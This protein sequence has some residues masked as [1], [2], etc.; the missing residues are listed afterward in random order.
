MLGIAGIAFFCTD[1]ASHLFCNEARIGVQAEEDSFAL[2]KL[3]KQE[4]F[5]QTAGISM[6]T[7][8][9]SF[10][11]LANTLLQVRL[12]ER[13]KAGPVKASTTVNTGVLKQRLKYIQIF[14]PFSFKR[15]IGDL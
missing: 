12:M 5:Q 3:R 8:K 2:C 1:R 14:K 7:L 10:R 11:A 6:A 9:G 13:E 4:A 15:S